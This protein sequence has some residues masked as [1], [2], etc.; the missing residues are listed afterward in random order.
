VI[1]ILGLGA[2]GAGVAA[3]LA[4]SGAEVT[5]HNRTASRAV[6]VAGVAVAASAGEAV[7]GAD[8]VV[9]CLSDEP[10]VDAVLTGDLLTAIKPDALIVNGSA[11]SPTYSRIL[12]ER[13]GTAGRRFVEAALVGN[14]V[15][16][17][18]GELRLFVCGRPEDVAEARARL[19]PV[20]R[21][22]VPVGPVGN[23][24]AL[25]LVFNLLLGAQ[26]AALAEAVEYGVAAGLDR[27][28]LLSVIG[29][30]GFSSKVLSFR[31]EIARSRRYAPAAFRSALMAKDL[32]LLLDAAAEASV[33]LPVTA[34]SAA[35]FEALVAA[36]DGDLDAAALLE[37][38]R[39]RAADGVRD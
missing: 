6:A 2:M 9:L 22:I 3:R 20:A 35:R 8:V 18:A 7:A 33:D 21:E 36:G 11:V 19:G 14:P 12:A 10:A 25:K 38:A 34:V 5:V 23:A 29:G 32:R 1:A 30:S 16:A 28:R 39:P 26:I 15:Q 13:V 17:R 24:A 37:P 27:D 4:E 31:A